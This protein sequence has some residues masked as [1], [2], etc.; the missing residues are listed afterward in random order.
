MDT[1]VADSVTGALVDERYRIRSRVS[2]DGLATVYIATDERLE[3]TVAVKLIHPAHSQDQRFVERFSDQAKA[4]ARLTHPNVAAVYD[5]GVYRGMPYLVME[6]VRGRTL[7]DLLAE[8]GRLGPLEALAVL[9]QV[10]AAVAAA[11]R[12]GL[13]HRDVKP[14]NILIAPA[15]GGGS[16]IDAVVKVAD[17]GLTQAVEEAGGETAALTEAAAYVAPE[18]ITGGRADPRTDVYSCGVVLYEMLTG[19]TPREPGE[20]SW[21]QVDRDVPPPSAQVAGLPTAVDDLVL[22]S[23]RRDPAARPT[24]AIALL[25]EVQVARDRL[26]VVAHGSRVAA[27]PTVPVTPIQA[28]T[29]VVPA[30]PSWAR[31][32]DRSAGRR[33]AAPPGEPPSLYG[34]A[35]ANP[36]RRRFLAGLI[37]ALGLLIAVGGW[38]F[39]VGRYT[40]TPSLVGQSRAQATSLASSEGFTIRT[41][42]GLYSETVP[43][44]QVMAQDPVATARIAK[45]GTITLTLSLGPER[46]KVPDENGQSYNN[47]VADLTSIKLVPKRV[48]VYDDNMP[49][50]NVLST[51]PAAGTLVKPGTAITVNVSNGPSP[52]KMPN[53]V[54]MDV[55]AAQQAVQQAG[56][57][58]DA[59]V[60]Q[61]SDKPANQ[62]ID[63]DPAADSGVVQG[64]KVKLVVSDGSQQPQPVPVPDLTGQTCPQAVGTLQQVGLVGVASD[65]GGTVH[66]ENPAPG[67]PVPPG[68]Q[69]QIVCYP[70]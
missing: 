57:V 51:D 64:Q 52:L 12:A 50:G 10:L 26:G 59:I 27:Q 69:V 45:G 29:R 61:P 68:T 47:A 67:T 34:R 43:K 41:G 30:R 2:L 38:Y 11:H 9:E 58:V 5:Q 24:D 7:R 20:A 53:L 16:L 4:I 13:V 62:V 55:N 14:E 21:Q 49:K 3:R 40:E 22:R 46:Y 32:P 6:Y 39:G 63:Q 18:L 28:P 60:S 33:R 36:V 25:A 65:G 35:N 42:K 31:L 56:L 70:P 48:D 37:A 1:T 15:P 19:Q 54:G 23:T 8:R 17:F 44:D 66:Q